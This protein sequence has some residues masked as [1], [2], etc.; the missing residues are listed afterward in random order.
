MKTYLGLIA[1]AALTLSACSGENKPAENTAAPSSTVAASESVTVVEASAP[2]VA[3][4]C[5]TLI[6]SN[7]AMQFDVKEI[8][9]KS[10]CKQYTI[11]LKHTGTIA[12]QAMGHNV[13]ISK[14]SDKDAVVK[15]GIDANI[16]ADYVKP[17]DERVVAQTKLIGGGEETSVTFDVAK[18]AK[19]EAYEYFCT[20]PGHAAL[21]S[22]KITIVE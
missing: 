9:I 7:D 8:S 19:S 3:D 10:S 6:N 15:D 12:K 1:A 4:E 20:F 16:E 21:M 5:S 13:V 22:G 11:T 14:V 18:L 17:N 2:V